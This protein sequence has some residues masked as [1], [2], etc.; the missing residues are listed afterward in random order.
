MG[1]VQFWHFILVDF[2]NTK[3]GEFHDFGTPNWSNFGKLNMAI[4]GK[5]HD[6]DTPKS[7]QFWYTKLVD[8]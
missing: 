5:F 1:D 2:W 6:Y 8:Y 3:F 4:F 7:N